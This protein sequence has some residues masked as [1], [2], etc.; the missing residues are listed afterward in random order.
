MKKCTELL[1]SSNNISAVN[2][3]NILKE[4]NKFRKKADRLP[5]KIAL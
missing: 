4:V 1:K 5:V 3:E 2:F